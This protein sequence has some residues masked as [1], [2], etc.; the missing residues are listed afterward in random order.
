MG[1]DHLNHL[2]IYIYI[3]IYIYKVTANCL[4]KRRG[5]EETK[6][7]LINFRTDEYM[8]KDLRLDLNQRLNNTRETYKG[9]GYDYEFLVLTE[10][11]L[12]IEK[13]K[14]SLRFYVEL[15]LNVRTRTKAILYNKINKFNC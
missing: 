9:Y 10:I 14:P 4:Y 1:L 13:T 5:E 11:Q 15:P 8:T 2:Y 12:N 6:T 3:Y 7:T